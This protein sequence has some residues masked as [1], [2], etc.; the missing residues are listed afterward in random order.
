M[1]KAYAQY[2]SASEDTYQRFSPWIRFIAIAG[3]TVHILLHF[4]NKVLGE[5]EP[6]I[7]RFTAI[8]LLS[9]YFLGHRLDKRNF[10]EILKRNF[11]LALIITG[12]LFLLAGYFLELTQAYPKET[13]LM[14]R[15]FEFIAVLGA[16]LLASTDILIAGIL[17]FCVLAP[18]AIL[19]ITFLAIDP[20]EINLIWILTATIYISIYLAIIIIARRQNDETRA[21]EIASTAIGSSIAHELRTPLL[22]IAARAAHLNQLILQ[23]PQ[24]QIDNLT[25]KKKALNVAE[26]PSAILDEAESAST[27]IDI[28]LVSNSVLKIPRNELESFNLD[29]AIR[30]AIDRFPYKSRVDRSIVEYSTTGSNPIRG[31]KLILIHV[32]FNLLKNSFNH[33]GITEEPSISITVTEAANEFLVSFSDNGSGIPAETIPKIFAP[34]FS[35]STF[36]SG[37]GLN[38]CRDSLA[39]YFGGTISCTSEIGE[40][41]RMDI[42]LPRDNG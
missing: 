41:T 16:V 30:E 40:F 32:F 6:S 19:A 3:I 14:R 26:L 18:V 22:S 12:P 10:T 29:E 1:L 20:T 4:S 31:S 11:L 39:T 28:F 13:I 24:I 33:L 2:I 25:D 37:I 38:F 7:L 36:G 21:R 23:S 42:V 9:L 27:L 34:D 15:A 35:T 5:S 17:A 8:G